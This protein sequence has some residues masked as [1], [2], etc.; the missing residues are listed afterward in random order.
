[1]IINSARNACKR[2]SNPEPIV[3]YDEELVHR[4][5]GR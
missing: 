4:T 5:L 3:D 1:M 2:T